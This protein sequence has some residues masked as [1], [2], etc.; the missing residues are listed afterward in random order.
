MI[1][2][3]R[4]AMYFLFLRRL[5]MYGI[6]PPLYPTRA[7][8]V[9]IVWYICSWIY[10]FLCNQCLSPLM[11]WVWISIRTRCTT[12]C[13]KVCQ[14]LATGRW[15]SPGPPFSTTNKT[16]RNDFTEILWKVAL[17]TIELTNLSPTFLSTDL[18][19]VQTVIFYSM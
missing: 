11:L 9:V 13:D 6:T 19:I 12:L 3:R 7:V 8:V 4:E 1:P 18:K 16:D 2:M 10:N 15:Y 14:W 5:Y 17:N